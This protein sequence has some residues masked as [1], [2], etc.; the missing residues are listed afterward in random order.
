MDRILWMRPQWL[1]HYEEAQSP[2]D[3]LP[4]AAMAEASSSFTQSPVP[5][6]D[7]VLQNPAMEPE[8][9]LVGADRGPDRHRFHVRPGRRAEADGRRA[10]TPAAPV[11]FDSARAS[12]GTIPGGSHGE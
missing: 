5:D 10:R 7:H 2:K 8:E 11:L 12:V 3:W 4:N 9:G 1:R 6:R